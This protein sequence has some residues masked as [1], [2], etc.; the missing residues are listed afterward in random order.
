MSKFSEKLKRHI[1]DNG[2]VIYQLAKRSGLDRTTIQRA[3]TG[4]RLPSIS[5]VECLSDYL[6][7]SP[8]EKKELLELYTIS[9][10]G[11]KVYTGRK[12]IKA[13]IER[14]VTIHSDGDQ[15]SYIHKSI[16]FSG[17]M[18]ADTALYEGQY[19]VNN[20]IR[21]VLEDEIT[22]PSPAIDLSVPFHHVFISDL[23]Y[24]LYLSLNGKVNIRNLVRFNKLDAFQDS[25]YN[26]EILSHVIP[27]AFSA[28]NGY[29]LYYYYD[30]YDSS[31]DIA[32]FMPYYIITSKRLIVL[33]SDFNTAI[34]YNNESIINTYKQYFDKA[35]TQS[36]QLIEQ[37][38]TCGDL[39][40]S[41]IETY[42]DSGLISHVM[43]PQP[44]FA[45]YYTDDM[46]RKHLKPELD[47]RTMLL[48]LLYSL[49]GKYRHIEERP[50]SLFSVEGLNTFTETGIIADLP[51]QYAIPFTPE[52][53]IM[54]MEALKRDIKSGIYQVY[55]VNSTQFKIPFSTIQVYKTNGISFFTTDNN[56]LINSAYMTEKSISEA[57]YDFFK[58]LPESS[59]LYD[60]EETV[61]IIDR[62]IAK[63]ES[64]MEAVS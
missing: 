28:G 15:P 59:M 10:I 45:W 17:K 54:L 3:I 25:N 48:E 31:R 47:N 2:L 52:E 33:S 35:I 58:S 5:F 13:M 32:L 8:V 22:H 18:N 56:G 61:N 50:V 38:I 43:E 53:R 64:K 57:F 41:Y 7:L 36:A 16:S 39:L 4:E 14:I 27:F 1:E 60:Q 11:E 40:Q 12:Y 20:M 26:L 6:R 24:Q 49:Y 30:N 44:C 29:Q 23:L 55:A 37:H 62:C 34:L 9:K 42:Q 19:I 46:I 63:C 51:I 21:D